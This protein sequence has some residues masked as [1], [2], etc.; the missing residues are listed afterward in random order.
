MSNTKVIDAATLTDVT[1]RIE[2]IEALIWEARKDELGTYL[3]FTD[4]E[5]LW[6]L[7]SYGKLKQLKDER[8]KEQSLPTNKDKETS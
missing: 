3:R 6:P 4:G 8:L 5:P 2:A 7:I 1:A